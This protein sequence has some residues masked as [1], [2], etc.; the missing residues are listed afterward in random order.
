MSSCLLSFPNPII[1]GITL[2][3]LSA[4]LQK[5]KGRARSRSIAIKKIW[6][7]ITGDG[8]PVF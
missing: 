3:Q 8:Q 1:F 5:T 7:T 4:A 6:L 2:N